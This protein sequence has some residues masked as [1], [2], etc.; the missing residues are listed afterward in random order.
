[1]PLNK[2]P[3]ETVSSG[4]EHPFTKAVKIDVTAVGGRSPSPSG[5]CLPPYSLLDLAALGSHGFSL[6][7]VPST[8]ARAGE[9]KE[10]YQC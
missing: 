8:R 7:A 1:M 9:L 2:T 10:G 4:S 3:R 6:A 5:R